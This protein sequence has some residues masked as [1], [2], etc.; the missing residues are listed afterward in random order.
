MTNDGMHDTQ[1][2]T[3]VAV[4][5]TRLPVE[6]RELVERNWGVLIDGE[7]LLDGNGFGRRWNSA[8]AAHHGGC[9]AIKLGQVAGKR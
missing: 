1:Y 7:L 2:T 3:V 6:R 5:L 9:L 4:H 8:A